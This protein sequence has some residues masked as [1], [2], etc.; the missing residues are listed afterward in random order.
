MEAQLEMKKIDKDAEVRVKE[1]EIE[2]QVKINANNNNTSSSQGQGQN[3][4]DL[5]M[6]LPKL[7]EEEHAR[8]S[9][10]NTR[11]HNSS[12]NN[13]L[14]EEDE[15]DVYFRTFERIAETCGV[16][17]SKWAIMLAPKLTGKAMKAYAALN[18]EQSKEYE[19]VKK[20]VLEKYEVNGETY[21]MKFRKRVRKA[22]ESVREWAQETMHNLEGWIEFSGVDGRD[23]LAIK[24]LI[25]MEHL[26]ESMPND[27]AVHIK[28]KKPQ[29]SDEMARL[30]DDYVANRGGSRYWQRSEDSEDT[31][32]K[33]GYTNFDPQSSDCNRNAEIEKSSANEEECYARQENCASDYARNAKYKGLKRNGANVRC[34]NCDG[35][36]HLKD[37]CT[38][39][40]QIRQTNGS[41]A[42]SILWCERGKRCDADGENVK[43]Q[44]SVGRYPN[45]KSI[46]CCE[47]VKPC[48]ADV[49]NKTGYVTHVEDT[50]DKVFKSPLHLGKYKYTYHP[51]RRSGKG[52]NVGSKA[53]QA[54][55]E[56]QMHSKVNTV[57]AQ[58]HSENLSRSTVNCGQRGNDKRGKRGYPHV[59]DRYR[60]QSVEGKDVCFNF[61]RWGQCSR[62][63]CRFRHSF[64]TNVFWP[65]Q[66]KRGRPTVDH[67]GNEGRHSQSWR[68]VKNQNQQKRLMD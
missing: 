67:W 28:D 29:S 12:T 6:K 57:D 22:D 21:R 46:L 24:E 54:N 61:C 60:R 26:F 42:K 2:A 33:K 1:M 34:Y 35:F 50:S 9:A 38:S 27:M 51:K 62:P 66:K 36:G 4:T 23:G 5:C 41:N 59:Y 68:D 32:G 11:S 20:V 40:R 45:V 56:S 30:A 8:V 63:H 3:Y 31:N 19:I 49:E 47:R 14:S 44:T 13:K 52:L 58:T 43:N 39:R 55:S 65:H 64:R 10:V 37:Q 7:S 18:M 48:G 16:E 25:N 17:K 53:K 15:V